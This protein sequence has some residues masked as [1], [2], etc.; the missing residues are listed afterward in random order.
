MPLDL[1]PKPDL[2]LPP[3]PAIVHASSLREASFLPGMFPGVVMGAAGGVDSFTKLMLHLNGA[4]GS[5]TFTDSSSLVHS[6]TRN[7]NP[8]IDT[9]QSRFGGASCLFVGGGTNRNRLIV[10]HH[11]DLA[12]GA[13]DFTID[14]WLRPTNTSAGNR[15]LWYKTVGANNFAINQSGTNIVL[16]AS[17]NGTSFNLANNRVV[18]SGLAANTWFHFAMA[19]DGSNWRSFSNGTLTDT[20]SSSATIADSS[21]DAA[22]GGHSGASLDFLGHLDE[23]RVSKGVARWKANFT[24]P[25]SPYS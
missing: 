19:R 3:K 23:I 13:S 1:P 7:G 10:P 24:P 21:G 22:I 9:T 14:F 25:N 2:W 11:A 4:D 5:T 6:V 15:T 12:F 20:L 18:A 17:S 16:Y 8:E